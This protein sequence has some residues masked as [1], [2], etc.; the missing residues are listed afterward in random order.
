VGDAIRVYVSALDDGKVA[1]VGF[2][3]IDPADP[4]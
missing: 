1:R 2:V 4:T 3:E